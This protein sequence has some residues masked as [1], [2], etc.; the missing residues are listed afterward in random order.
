M[1]RPIRFERTTCSLGNC[2]SI[3]LSYGRAASY[4]ISPMQHATQLAIRKHLPHHEADQL[5]NV[6]NVADEI[7]A[8]YYFEA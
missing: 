8:T 3:L 1:A 5:T 6:Y 2:R 7:K 4:I